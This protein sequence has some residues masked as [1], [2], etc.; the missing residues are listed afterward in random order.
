MM[1]KLQEWQLQDYRETDIHHR[2]V[3]HLYGLYPGNVI[4]ETDQELKKAC[5]ISLNRRGKSGNRMVYGLE[6]KSLGQT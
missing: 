4:K 3:S 2:H 5:E 1:D 6:S